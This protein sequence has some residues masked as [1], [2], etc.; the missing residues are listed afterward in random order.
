LSAGTAGNPEAARAVSRCYGALFFAVFGGAWLFLA[1]YAFGRLSRFEGGLIAAVMVLFVIAA[2]RLQRRGK[3]AGKD[4]VPA[5][6]RRRNDRLFGIVNTV[7]WIAVFLVFL[8]FPRIGHADLAIPAV[9]LI[10]GL[11]FFPMP[12][13]Y[14]HTANL[15]TGACIAVWAILC[16][17]LFQGDRMIGFAAV[18]VGFAL[19]LSAAWALKTAVRLLRG[20]AD[21]RF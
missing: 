14:R 13:L 6:E 8:I 19:W 20:G 17:M 3:D 9:A 1:A 10:V 4:A 11:H 18:G 2:M 5:E 12:P 16:P 21:D 15:V 7:T